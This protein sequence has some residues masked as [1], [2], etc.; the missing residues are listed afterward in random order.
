MF[1]FLPKL[2]ETGDVWKW[3]IRWQLH[4]HSHFCFGR[5]RDDAGTGAVA[6][7]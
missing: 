5:S 2:R 4:R 6:W 1:S 3:E 7:D